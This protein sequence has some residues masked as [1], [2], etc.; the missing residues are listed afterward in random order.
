M[1][2]LDL[3]KNATLWENGTGKLFIATDYDGVIF[4]EGNG[5]NED[6][7]VATIEANYSFADVGY[8][9]NFELSYGLWDERVITTDYCGVWEISRKQDKIA[10]FGADIQEILEMENFALI[11]GETLATSGVAPDEVETIAMKRVKKTKPYHLFKW[12]TCPKDG[13]YN[14]FYFIKTILASEFNIPFVNL[15]RNDASYPRLEFEVAESGNHII[16]K[17]LPVSES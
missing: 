12:V 17:G 13:K 1:G 3:D 4:D 16:R 8:L 10:G 5:T 15:Q 14:V 6:T 2:V 7:I 11:I 9:E